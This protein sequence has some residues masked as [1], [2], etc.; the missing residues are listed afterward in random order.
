MGVVGRHQFT[1][2][3]VV[4]SEVGVVPGEVGDREVS[5]FVV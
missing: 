4:R 3:R 5:P 2:S 1:G